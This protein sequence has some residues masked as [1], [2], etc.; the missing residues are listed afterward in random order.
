VEAAAAVP[1]HIAVV[2]TVAT[3][4]ISPSRLIVPQS[5]LHIIS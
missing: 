3:A 2:A 4:K 5:M 1:A